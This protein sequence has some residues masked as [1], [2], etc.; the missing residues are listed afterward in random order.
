MTTNMSNKQKKEEFVQ[1]IN[2]Y[3][4]RVKSEQK[5]EVAL[6]HGDKGLAILEALTQMKINTIHLKR[7]DCSILDDTPN[8]TTLYTVL[9]LNVSYPNGKEVS[10][11]YDKGYMA[12]NETG[13]IPYDY[14]DDDEC[15]LTDDTFCSKL[16]K[17]TLLELD[18][19]L[20]D[21]C[22]EL[23]DFSKILGNV[24]WELYETIKKN[25]IT[26]FREFFGD[27]YKVIDINED[28]QNEVCLL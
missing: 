3:I 4:Q 28:I 15:I 9:E 2:D 18:E 19:N 10:L 25:K 6:S 14:D 13:H 8:G 11:F 22:F 7:Q 26:E 20:F 17:V 16:E 21:A 5:L 23:L 12:F 1:S 24:K 27:N